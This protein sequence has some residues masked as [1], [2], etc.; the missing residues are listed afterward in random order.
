[1]IVMSFNSMII[2]IYNNRNLSKPI[3]G[4]ANVGDIITL[5]GDKANPDGNGPIY[6]FSRDRGKTC[7]T[8]DENAF[9]KEDSTVP[10]TWAWNHP[11]ARDSEET[12]FRAKVIQ[13]AISWT[14][15]IL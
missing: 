12:E 3:A 8:A 11:V 10:M 1:M 2:T 6:I 7:F 5:E 14:W 4:D 13:L 9:V 15:V